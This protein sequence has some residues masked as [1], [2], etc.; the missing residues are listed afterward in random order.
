MSTLLNAGTVRNVKSAHQPS[1]AMVATILAGH[2][3]NMGNM[4][5]AF[6]EMKEKPNHKLASDSGVHLL[7]R[8]IFYICQLIQ[9][10]FSTRRG[11]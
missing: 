1:Y 3:Q 4:E 9:A 11:Y 7:G 2:I 8:I 5:P 6:V 10:A